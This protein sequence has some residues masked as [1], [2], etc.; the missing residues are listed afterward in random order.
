[1]DAKPIT[2]TMTL[3]NNGTLTGT[4][5]SLQAI[6]VAGSAVGAEMGTSKVTW[7]RQ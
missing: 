5:Q 6:M 1:M 4:K 2:W 3:A 7:T